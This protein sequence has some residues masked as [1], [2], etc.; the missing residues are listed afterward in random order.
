[1]LREKMSRMH[2]KLDFSYRSP[3]EQEDAAGRLWAMSR[4]WPS[5]QKDASDSSTQVCF[6]SSLTAG[7]YFIF[8]SFPSYFHKEVSFLTRVKPGEDISS[9]EYFPSAY[10]LG[11][12][13]WIVRVLMESPDLHTL[14]LQLRISPPF[15]FY[16]FIIIKLKKYFRRTSEYESA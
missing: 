14:L 16:F 6:T 13:A 4:C 10:Q 2:L 1:M 3:S 11:F 12:L 15:F 8:V 9:S 5:G 7:K